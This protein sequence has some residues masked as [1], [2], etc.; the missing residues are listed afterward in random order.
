MKERRP[1]GPPACRAMD[2]PG[3][4][5]FFAEI[6]DLLEIRGEN[7]FRIRAY[8][9]AARTLETLAEPVD[10]LASRGEQA[11]VALPGIGRDLAR[12]IRE[13][14]RTGRLEFLE[15]LKA[16][17]PPTLVE[18]LE[19]PGLGPRR[20]RKL[21][22]E[23]GVVSLDDLEAALAE[24][25]L[26]GLEGFGP[27][28]IAKIARGLAER[29]EQA[30]RVRLDAADRAAETIVRQLA[31]RRRG[32]RLVVAGSLRRRRETVH[33]LDLLATGCTRGLIERF[34]ALDGVRETLAAGGSRASVRLASGLQVDL[35]VV[36]EE[37]FGAAL[38]YFTGSKEH[39]IALRRRARERGLRLNEYGLFDGE[40]R[41]AGARE[42]DVYAA[43]D[44][45]PI[46]PE[47]REN[48][49]EIEAAEQGRLP[50]LVSLD[51]IRGDL[52]MHT[53]W[54]DGRDTI[55]AMAC[56]ARERGYEYIAITDHGPTVRVAGGLDAAR[57]ARQIEEIDAINERIEGLRV[58]KGIETDILEDGT[59]DL[60]DD[61][62]A[63]LDY[64]LATVHTRLA[65]SRREM[66]RRIVRALRH[67][68]VSALGHPTGRL[69]GRRPPY[70]VDF[71]EIVRA[72]AGEG[73]LLEID[74]HPERLDLDDHHARRAA[75]AGVPIVISTDAH[76]AAD[77]ALMRY[78][79][80]QARRAW[81]TPDHVANARPLGRF[82]ALLRR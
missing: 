12:K 29:R 35:R 43:L 1:S 11:L 10:E 34:V 57:L 25:R 61:V 47:L 20:V 31:G 15:R 48:R 52:Q 67:P 37:S 64:V 82:L 19:V 40:R 24:G 18:L 59:L 41:I 33:D 36:P 2:N 9:N 45:P 75:E 60:P 38:Q 21:W 70:E 13:L 77:L 69:I 71:D 53:T 16:E 58:L 23:A 42:D 50:A 78:G 81:L 39:G 28:L 74:G 14:A 7:P 49:G 44:L 3:Y 32:L 26:A 27:T 17:I 8:R 6:A 65:L 5:R 62:L 76:A 68:R 56:A 72:A 46:P 73:K 55:E 66:T 22:Q 63:K 54:S 51:D 80:D 4:A 30:G 79:V